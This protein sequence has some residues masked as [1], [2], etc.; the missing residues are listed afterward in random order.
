MKDT[1]KI[2]KLIKGGEAAKVLSEPD[3]VEKLNTL[4]EYE[5]IEIIDGVVVLSEKGRAFQKLG[6]EAI[7][8]GKTK[9]SLQVQLKKSDG[10]EINSVLMMGIGILFFFLLSLL[11][12]LNMI[13]YL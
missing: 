2:L 1:Y 9:R 13:S 3:L 5:L 12:G 8:K 7:M 4:N 10:W 11:I 6:P